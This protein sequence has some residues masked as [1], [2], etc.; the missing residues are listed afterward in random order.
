MRGY[1]ESDVFER[2]VSGKSYSIYLVSLLVESQ[3]SA[4]NEISAIIIGCV[5]KR[6][7]VN[8]FNI[9]LGI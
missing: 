4:E 9:I 2:F 3:V 8:F 6:R 1:K 5:H 7:H